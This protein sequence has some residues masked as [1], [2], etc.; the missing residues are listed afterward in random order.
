MKRGFFKS[1]IIQLTFK[2]PMSNIIGLFY[3]PIHQF[4]E[5]KKGPK[6]ENLVMEFIPNSKKSGPPK[7]ARRGFLAFCYRQKIRSEE[8]ILWGEAELTEAAVQ[9]DST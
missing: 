3:L 1:K 9:C 2:D 7:N 4:G 6:T 5:V 8:G